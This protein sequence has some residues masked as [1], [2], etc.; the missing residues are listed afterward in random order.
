METNLR[1]SNEHREKI[2]AGLSGLLADSHT[3]YLKT[4][5]FH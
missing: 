2:A 3:L 5:N 1:I 4:H